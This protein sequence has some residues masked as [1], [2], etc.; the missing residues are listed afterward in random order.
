M[1]E[2]TLFPIAET[3]CPAEEADDGDRG[4]P[5]VQVAVRNQ[6]EMIMTDLDSL[7]ADDHQVRIVWAFMQ[8][9][10]LSGLYDGSRARGQRP[11]RNPIDPKILMAL[12]MNAV[13]DGVGS[14]R[15]L[16]RRCEEDVGYRW[17][18][19]GVSVNYHTLSDFRVAHVEVL[20]ELL[21]KNVAALMAEG[22]VEMKRV[23]Q[24]GMRVRASAGAASYRR[25]KTLERCHQEATEQVKALRK[26]LETDPGA[27]SKRQRAARQRHERLEKALEK[28]EEL[29]DKEKTKPKSR[30]K[31][32]GELR[33]SMTDPEISPM[34]MA[35]GGFRPAVNVQLCTDTASQIITGVDVTASGNDNG[36]MAPMVEQHHERYEK[37]P[38]E[39]LVDG[40]FAKQEDIE[41]VSQ[42][43]V[44]CTVY[45][46]V[47]KPRAPGR[48]P[49]QPLPCDSP[50]VAKWRERMGTDEAKEI[51]KERAATAECVN[52]IARNRGLWRFS[53][54]GLNK[55][56]AVVLWYVLAHN[57]MRA[58]TLTVA[59]A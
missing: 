51:Y 28:L 2:N 24:D 39:M 54:R 21:S 12:W 18:C 29:Q 33:A 15:E 8:R 43:E 59:T 19:G 10:E 53:V 3:T 9:Q 5:R 38:A 6:V 7:I 44:R 35:D 31:K 45:V 50:A 34:K 32:P 13:L 22:L 16:E 58:H 17:I 52:A 20:D 37:Y 23:A 47:H 27:Q 30:Q 41:Q 49:F 14:A 57:M 48:D 1:T 36:Q 55:I 46:P 56:K 26:E 40:G 42:P 4:A 25:R 11:G